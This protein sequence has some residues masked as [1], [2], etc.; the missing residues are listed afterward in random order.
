MAQMKFAIAEIAA[1]FANSNLT[2]FFSVLNLKN[3]QNLPNQ[4]GNRSL[5]FLKIDKLFHVATGWYGAERRNNR[6]WRGFGF[7]L[8]FFVCR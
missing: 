1:N 3:L 7:S 2:H 6:F 5:T 4:E 8:R